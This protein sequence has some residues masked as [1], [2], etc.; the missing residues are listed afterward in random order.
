MVGSL[1]ELECEFS[2]IVRGMPFLRSYSGTIFAATIGI[3]CVS[4]CNGNGKQLGEQ[5]TTIC[6]IDLALC[7]LM[8]SAY[9]ILRH[10]RHVLWMSCVSQ[11]CS[12]DYENVQQ[13]V[14]L[15]VDQLVQ[16]RMSIT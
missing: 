2:R 1:I 9:Q 7:R 4:R 10:V 14:E 8:W 16:R 3:V 11:L 12:D 13:Y 15:L 6:C 5:S